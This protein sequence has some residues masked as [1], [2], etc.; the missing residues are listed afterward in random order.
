MAKNLISAKVSTSTIIDDIFDLSDRVIRDSNKISV[1]MHELKSRGSDAVY[2]YYVK[3]IK[4]VMD[5][6]VKFENINVYYALNEVLK[7]NDA[8]KIWKFVGLLQD[9][10][11][12]HKFN[13]NYEKCSKALAKTKDVKY[14]L[15]WSEVYLEHNQDN[16]ACVIESRDAMANA[17]MVALVDNL[18]EEQ[19]AEATK[20]VKASKNKEAKKEL[21]YTLTDRK[22]D[23]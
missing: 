21:K 6:E 1:Y 9:L 8:E 22:N 10:Q 16:I 19:I 5:E 23:L 14:N 12:E 18:T 15:F 4:R 13:I 7:L 11:E 2:E 17:R 3:Y 20:I